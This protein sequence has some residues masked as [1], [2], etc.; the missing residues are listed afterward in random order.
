MRAAPRAMLSTLS[1]LWVRQSRRERYL[2]SGLAVFLLAT[3]A[4]SLAW[5]PAQARLVQAEHRYLQQRALALDVQR[6]QPARARWTAS[7]PLSVQVSERAAEAGLELHQLDLEGDQLRMTVS[8][9]ALALLA[10]LE[11][12]EQQGGQL[13]SLLLTKQDKRLQARLVLE[14]PGH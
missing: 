8:G 7:Q 1:G 4:Y 10:W 9:D 13:Q 11:Q 2:L 5:Q 6:A 14:A 3:L 12:T